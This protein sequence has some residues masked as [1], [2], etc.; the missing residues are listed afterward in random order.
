MHTSRRSVLGMALVG[1]SALSVPGWGAAPNDVFEHST[2][3]YRIRV[4]GVPPFVEQFAVDSLA[5]GKL[6]SNVALAPTGAATHRLAPTG[7]GVAMYPME[8]PRHASP[9][10]VIGCDRSSIS[11][12]GTSR[13]E[14]PPL[15]FTIDPDLCHATVL[16]LLHERRRIALPALLHFPGFGTMRV[17]GAAGVTIG[18]DAR[19][20]LAGA[21][22]T[23]NPGAERSLITV[24]FAPG[25]SYTLTTTNIY[26]ER[27]DSG[28]PQYDGYRRDFLNIFQVNPRLGVLAN[29]S[30]S[31]PCAF[32]LYMAALMAAATPPLAQGL[33]AL[34]LVR[35]TLD[36]YIGGM[37]AYGLVGYTDRYEGAD[38]ISWKSAYDSLDSYPSLVI[39][40]CVYIEASGDL[41]WGRANHAAIVGWLTRQLARDRDG[42]GLIEYEASG[43]A[44]SWNGHDRPA[45]WWDTIGYGDKDA[46]SNALTYW[47]LT[48]FA[49]VS[50]R[51]GE[52]SV[53]DTFA[54]HAARLKRAYAPALVNPATG[55]VAG[56]RSRDGKLHDYDFLFVNALAVLEDLVPAAEQ[57]SIM[58]RLL[59]RMQTVGL[60]DF[61]YGLPGNLTAI[62]HEDYTTAEHRWG[63]P[64]R[65][66]GSDAF[67]I[68]E[69]GGA[70]AC[71][72]Y[73]TLA[74]LKKV[75]LREA[76]DRI[77]AQM[78]S[79][80][81]ASAFQGRC[82][83]G[84]SRDWR[85]WSGEC[86][87]YEGFL[88]D[89]F[90]PL[91]AV[92]EA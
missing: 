16:G 47:A 25:A 84:M 76:H 52:T 81:S 50:A 31:D 75:G 61:R 87:G 69:N 66:D 28:Q 92:A 55:N 78:L 34:D 4:S 65:A 68:Y 18:F 56:W 45:N 29:N 72:A 82:A 36:R 59:A 7:S 74:A 42:D 73:F 33:A 83:N 89:A 44:G 1:S 21:G 11:L 27:T 6:A 32:T 80:Y 23:D 14:A 35:A 3:S 58:L 90:L 30:A 9:D 54:K 86:W 38:T 77:L 15:A 40:A 43:N 5:Q 39:A 79:S 85:T 48:R 53:A 8:A 13:A 60:R 63:G 51:L 24:E 17:T 2:P 37:K 49:A 71:F 12:Q 62:R 22:V 64:A 20:S 57:R 70:T 26:V 41:A 67:Q 91:L 10:W 19:R 88:V 46:Y